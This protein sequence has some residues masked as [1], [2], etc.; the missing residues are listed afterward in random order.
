MNYGMTDLCHRKESLAYWINR[1]STDLKEPDK[2][3]VLSFIKYMEDKE[4]SILWIIRCIRWQ[5]AIGLSY[6]F[7]L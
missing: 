2:T 3:D 4:S 7:G 6:R 5:N 1:I